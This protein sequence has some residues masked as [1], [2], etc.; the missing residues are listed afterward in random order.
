MKLIRTQGGVYA[1]NM[2]FKALPNA[3]YIGF[4][5]T[6]I[7]RGEEEITKNIFGVSI[8]LFMILNHQ[9]RM[10]QHYLYIFE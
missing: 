10:V 8:F 2:R 3:S 4:T 1:R 6:P 7:I 9:S 5:G